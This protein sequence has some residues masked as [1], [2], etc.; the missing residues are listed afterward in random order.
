MAGSDTAQN[1]Y[2]LLAE[3]RST[4]GYA[5]GK[6]KKASGFAGLPM[7]TTALYAAAEASLPVAMGETSGF[8]FSRGRATAS[9]SSMR[10][11]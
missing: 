7:F 9:T 4:P 2:G 8:A 3:M 5:L 10:L 1:V 11:A 6:K